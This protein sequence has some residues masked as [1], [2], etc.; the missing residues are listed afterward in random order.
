MLIGG[1]VKIQFALGNAHLTKFLLVRT[2]FVPEFVNIKNFWENV[3]SKDFTCR[4]EAI[5]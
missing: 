1:R 2:Q 3:V 5:W 4:N